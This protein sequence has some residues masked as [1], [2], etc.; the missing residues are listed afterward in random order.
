M[1]FS[2]TWLDTDEYCYGLEKVKIKTDKFISQLKSRGLKIEHQSNAPIKL[3]GNIEKTSTHH[4]VNI[5]VLNN[6]KKVAEYTKNF[7]IAFSGEQSKNKFIQVLLTILQSTP[8]RLLLPDIWSILLKKDRSTDLHPISD[9]LSEAIIVRPA[10]ETLQSVPLEVSSI[11][12]DNNEYFLSNEKYLKGDQKDYCRF[13]EV[14][15]HIFPR[16]LDEHK[17]KI[18]EKIL[19]SLRISYPD[20]EDNLTYIQVPHEEVYQQATFYR[21]VC[22]NDFINLLVSFDGVG[23]T[24][25]EWELSPAVYQGPKVARTKEE[26]KMM[27]NEDERIKAFKHERILNKLIN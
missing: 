3:I 17:N 27:R 5:Q 8:T 24:V 2:S 10:P 14:K 1:Y 21:I 12:I 7:R 26:Q 20:K 4:K 23:Q 22:E 9:F 25:E 13:G 18:E 15:I 16:Y 11:N 19:I 6:D